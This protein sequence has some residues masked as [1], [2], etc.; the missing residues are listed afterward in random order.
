MQRIGANP[1]L[2]V[3]P[4]PAVAA[5]DVP[6]DTALSW[7]P[8]Q[9]AATHDVYFGKAFADVNTA[10]RT[11]ALGVLVSQGQTETSLPAGRRGSIMD[12]RT[13]GGS[14]RSIRRP[15][16]RSSK[17]TRGPSPSSRMSIRS[18][19][20]RPR[21]PAPRRAW[22]RKRRSTGPDSMT[23]DQ[24]GDRADRPC[25][26]APHVAELDS[27][28]LRPSLQGERDVVWNSN[29]IIEAAIGFGAK[30]VTVEYS[31]DGTTW[32]QVTD[33][34]EFGRGT[35]L[36]TLHRQYDGQL[37][38]RVGEVRETDDPQPV[39]CGS[40]MQSERGPVLLCPGAGATA[41]AGGGRDRRQRRCHLELAS[42]PG[43]GLAQGVLRHR[44]DRRSRGNG[45][46]HDGARP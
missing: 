4:S 13:T 41:A 27:V 3:M 44:P 33:V 42:R 29:Q 46:G 39:G 20:S 18:R 37:G 31:I 12:R 17:G 22:A 5:K 23:G 2:A 19:A 32:T 15:T 1:G 40:P 8:G 38:R 14:M 28:C 10:G 36:D 34:P 7:T 21:R 24:H 26:S 16:V 25:G 43:G 11:S 30:N 6:T 45:R 35:G 9:F